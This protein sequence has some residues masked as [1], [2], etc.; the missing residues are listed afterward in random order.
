MTEIKLRPAEWADS[1]DLLSWRNDPD[2]R[3]VSFDQ[4]IV[5]AEQ[6]KN[7]LE[8]TLSGTTRRLIIAEKLTGEKIGMVRLDFEGT[9]FVEISINLAPN[10]RGQGYGSLLIAKVCQEQ[11]DLTFLARAKESNP[12][13]VKAFEKAG[14]TKLFSYDDCKNGK[15]IILGKTNG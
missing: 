1:E 5:K 7:W 12:A 10:M 11:S 8:K 2:T 15:I 6:H 14:F 13:S 4:G 3:R 9:S